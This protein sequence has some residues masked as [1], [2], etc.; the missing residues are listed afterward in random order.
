MDFD[1]VE[2]ADALKRTCRDME[3]WWAEYPCTLGNLRVQLAGPF[4]GAGIPD[5]L[6]QSGWHAVLGR[7]H[8]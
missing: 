2:L 3:H 6:W 4:Q 8:R 7:D 5:E 1:T